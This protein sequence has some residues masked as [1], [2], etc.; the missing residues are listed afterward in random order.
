MTTA[1]KTVNRS[2]NPYAPTARLKNQAL[3]QDNPYETLQQRTQDLIS[4]DKVISAANE[5]KQRMGQQKF[6]TEHFGR[7]EFLDVDLID[8]NVDI[9]RFLETSHIA[10]HII[11]YFDPRIMQPINV[12]YIKKT[13]RYSA[14]DGQQSSAAFALMMHF[15][16]FEPGTLIPCKVVD[17]DLRVPGSS[18]VGEA[19]GN[20]AFRWLNG[21]GR[22]G[23][24]AYFQHRSRVN[25]VRLY[26]SEMTEDKQA[27]EIQQVLERHEMFPA[28]SK[29]AQA[30]RALPGMVTH[31][32]GVYQIAGLGAP[33]FEESIKDLDWALGWHQKYFPSVKGVDGGFILAFGRLHSYFRRSANSKNKSG[34]QVRQSVSITPQL[35]QELYL[36]IK[37]RHLTP[38]GFHENCQA[39]LKKW[40]KDNNVAY[41]WR[42]ACLTPFLVMDWMDSGGTAPMV[43]VPL[44][45]E[46]AGM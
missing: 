33:G 23:M 13:G 2:V 40:H 27:E 28:P 46:F 31:I 34:K 39:R 15:G 42:N 16:L 10:E 21:K 4:D 32:S 5:L 43:E 38:K 22:S 6:S 26:D 11:Q 1:T 9:Q 45:K 25:G 17:D 12:I 14:W 44:L 7:L 41:S 29:D 19:M 36:M 20:M 3:T 30:R 35:E 18:L 37:N 8:I 24:D